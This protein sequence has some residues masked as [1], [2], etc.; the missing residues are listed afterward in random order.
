[1]PETPATQVVDGVWRIDCGGVNAYLVADD[2]GELI[3][4]DTGPPK[5]SDALAA[6]VAAA[7]HRLDKV[8]TI[9]VTH[10][11]IDHAGSLAELK[12]R[13]GAQTAMNSLD[14][15]VVSGAVR[16]PKPSLSGRF[17]GVSRR[18]ERIA[19]DLVLPTGAAVVPVAGLGAVHTPGHSAGHVSYLLDRAGG[20]LFTGDAVRHSKGQVL[21]PSKAASEDLAIAQAS[22][23]A[24]TE[25]TFEVACFG[26]GDP[27]GSGARQGFHD[28]L[29]EV[30]AW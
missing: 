28:C 7:G 2:S 14:A 4:V 29:A 30:S 6:A 18:P 19:V 5:H 22:L 3:L 26:H 12:R 16:P 15:E 21:L 1:M 11:H 17:S 20:V 25:L 27:V 24:L 9:L 10:R 8:G 23:R 13:T